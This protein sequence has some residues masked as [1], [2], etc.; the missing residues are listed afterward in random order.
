MQHVLPGEAK[1]LKTQPHQGVEPFTVASEVRAVGVVL[2]AVDLHHQALIPEQEV[3][4]GHERA[5]FGHDRLELGCEPG[6]MED[7][8]G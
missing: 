6:P 4:S 8:P 2:E 5:A 7:E 1:D 3:D